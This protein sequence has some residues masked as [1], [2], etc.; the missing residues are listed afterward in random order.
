[1]NFRIRF[2]S[3]QILTLPLTKYVTLVGVQILS[4]LKIK[5]INH[6]SKNFFLRRQKN[7][8]D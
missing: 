4:K 2:T 6:T 5:I 1:M 3:E 7:E 8:I